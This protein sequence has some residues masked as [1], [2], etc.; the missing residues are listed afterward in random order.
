MFCY[1]CFAS[2]TDGVRELLMNVS[3]EVTASNSSTSD[4][5]LYKKMRLDVPKA[6]SGTTTCIA[7]GNKNTDKRPFH[8][9][10]LKPEARATVFAKTGIFVSSSSRAC[11]M[12][13]DG[14]F[15]LPECYPNIKV[16]SRS[17]FAASEEIQNLLTE[18]RNLS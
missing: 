3:E 13:F 6:S 14:H 15:L 7:C 17:R 8:S 11:N 18:M 9:K 4:T 12:N 2:A 1:S 10:R 16:A 5:A